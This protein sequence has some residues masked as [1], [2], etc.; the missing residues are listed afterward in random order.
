MAETLEEMAAKEIELPHERLDRELREHYRAVTNNDLVNVSIC[1]RFNRSIPAYEIERPNVNVL[2]ALEIVGLHDYLEKACSFVPVGA[3]E[4]EFP[5][6]IVKKIFRDEDG[7]RLEAPG[8]SAIF[9]ESEFIPDLFPGLTIQE[10]VKV[11]ENADPYLLHSIADNL[12]YYHEINLCKKGKTKNFQL[13]G[14]DRLC[15]PGF[16]Q[17]FEEDYKKASIEADVLFYGESNREN[18]K[19]LLDIVS[20]MHYRAILETAEMIRSGYQLGK[21][22]E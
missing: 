10:R 11:L 12:R 8:Y 14:F 22:R 5:Y 20:T 17:E 3:T 18:T 1:D 13:N 4:W 2:G 19:N 7:K 21:A 16:S 6:E 15:L 9:D